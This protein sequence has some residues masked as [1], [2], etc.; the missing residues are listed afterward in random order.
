MKRFPDAPVVPHFLGSDSCE[1]VFAFM[2]T[3]R[4]SGRRTNLDAGVLAYGLE[5]R[6]V[7]SGLTSDPMFTAHTRGQ[8]VLKPVVSLPSESGLDKGSEPAIL[9]LG[10]VCIKVKKFKE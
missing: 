4:Y 7:C 3:S 10:I 5:R 9:I 8:N 1:Q 2:R 6:N